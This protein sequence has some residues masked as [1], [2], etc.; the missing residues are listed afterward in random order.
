MAK[1]TSK[2]TESTPKI[3]PPLDVQKAQIIVNYIVNESK[4]VDK[5]MGDINAILMNYQNL[6]NDYQALHEA[7]MKVTEQDMVEVAAVPI[8]EAPED[9]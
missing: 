5:T 6:L 2:P 7:Y 1:R 8:L 3:F 4:P 9:G